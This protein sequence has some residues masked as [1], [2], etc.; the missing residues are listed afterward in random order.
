MSLYLYCA[1]RRG[2][3]L[4]KMDRWMIQL[5]ALSSGEMRDFIRGDY[6]SAWWVFSS[7]WVHIGCTL[8]IAVH[9]GI[10]WVHLIMPTKVSDATKNGCPLK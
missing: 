2:R 5:R 9:C 10:E 3:A 7:R 1:V 4:C 8:V 6:Y